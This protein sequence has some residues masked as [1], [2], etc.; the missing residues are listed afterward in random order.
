M[1]DSSVHPSLHPNCYHQI[2]HTKFNLKIHFSPEFII[3]VVHEFNWQRAFSNL[4]INGSVF[5][6]NKTILKVISNFISHEPV[7]CDERDPP[8]IN[9][10]IKNLI[11]D[12]NIHYK[13]YLRRDKYT[14]VIEEFKLLQKKIVNLTNDSRDRFYS[15]KSNKL[16][17]FHVSPK[18]ILVSFKNGFEK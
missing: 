8:W 3:R 17:N 7:I 4:N 14:K 5:F 13:K 10:R 12:K 9:A 1:V 11:N 18:S 6:F 2:V 15:R 16:N